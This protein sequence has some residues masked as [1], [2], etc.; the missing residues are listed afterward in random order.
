M[1]S[2]RTDSWHIGIRVINTEML[3]VA[4]GNESG[5]VLDDLSILILLMAE[6]ISR[7]YNVG[8]WWWYNQ[9]KGQQFFDL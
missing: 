4:F 7:W 5:L 6:C 9:V 1:E 3:S 2:G 8:V